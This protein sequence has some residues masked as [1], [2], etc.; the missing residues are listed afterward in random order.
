MIGTG[1]E[2]A[3]LT[4]TLPNA[5]ITS[6]RAYGASV[7]LDGC[8]QADLKI[9]GSRHGNDGPMVTVQS[10]ELAQSVYLLLAVGVFGM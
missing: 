5:D 1:L 2:F 9:T 3:R 8:V 6:A 10:I 7:K 4:N